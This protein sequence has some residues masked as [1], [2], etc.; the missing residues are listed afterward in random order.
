M[1]ELAKVSNERKERTRALVYLLIRANV[2]LGLPKKLRS[3]RT[4]PGRK[5]SSFLSGKVSNNLSS[6]LNL[7][8]Q[9]CHAFH[10]SKNLFRLPFSL[11]LL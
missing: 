7:E 10:N 5:Q 8:T 2:Y 6:N 4:E 11:L 1:L 3:K 9:I